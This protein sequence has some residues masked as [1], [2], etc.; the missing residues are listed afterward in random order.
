V[1]DP[2]GRDG[3][4][5]VAYV[6]NG[7]QVAYSWHH[8]MVEMIGYDL[9][10]EGRIIRGGYV[11]MKCGTDGLADARNKAVKL[12]LKEDLADWLFWVDTD[13]GFAADT[14]DRLLAAADPVERPVVGGLAFTQKEEESDLMGGWRC[15]AAPTV[16]DWTVLDDGQMGFSVRWNYPPGQLTRCAGT[17][18]ACVLIHRSVFERV[19]EKFG[20]WYDRVPNTTTGQLLSEDLALCLRAGALDIPV[21]VH[22]GVRTTHQKT[23]WLAEDDYYGQVALS[24]LAPPVPAATEA[25][26]VIVP[27]LRRPQNAAPFME[28]LRA[29]G[30]DLAAVYAVADPGPDADAWK[31]A[32][33]TVLHWHGPPPGTFAERVN[34]GYQVT[35]EPWLLLAGDDVRFHPGWLDHA[36]HAARDGADVVGTNDLHN[37]RVT[38]GEHSPHPMIRRAYADEQ[39]A[40]WDGPGVVCHEGYRH[41][42][43]D[44]EIVTAAKQ[45]GAWVMAFHSKVEHL[46]PMWGLAADDETYAIGREHME[47]GRELFEKRLAEHS[48]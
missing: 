42:F 27:T 1:A 4:V 36:Q 6:Y 30:A 25:T 43:V 48:A 35:D 38:A 13:M 24:Q 29:S 12:F 17:G 8:S 16:F 44:D 7:H 19:Q 32:G 10:H 15:R 14:V 40:S 47:S 46:H 33:A 28:S 11:A 18:S 9:C 20:T 26:A 3:A 22:T 5:A 39:G 2:E 37:P 21:H 34:L 45:R 31:E 23:L 41:W